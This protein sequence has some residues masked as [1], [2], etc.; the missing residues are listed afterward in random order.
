MAKTKITAL[1]ELTDTNIAIGDL[2]P[3]VDISDTSQAA[4]G[5][6]K[7]VTITSLAT[8]VA[9][10]FSGDSPTFVN[11]TTTGTTTL[12]DASGDAVTINAATI[13]LA[14]DTNFVLS[15]GV[16]GVS[17]DTDVLS[18]D[19]TNDRVGIGQTSPQSKIDA[20]FTNFDATTYPGYKFY[21]YQ[22]SNTATVPLFH[23]QTGWE[24]TRTAN[25][26]KVNT[27]Q[28]DAGFNIL[29]NGNVGIG[30]TSPGSPLTVYGASSS[31]AVFT[32]GAGSGSFTDKVFRVLTDTSPAA[33]GVTVLRNG[34]VGIGTSSFGT[35]AVAVLGLANATAPTSSPAG[36]GQLYV[37][38]GALKYRGSSGTITT[39]GAA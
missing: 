14:N 30:E 15:G 21:G 9:S 23:I 33:E 2:I 6:T 37:E 4:S 16:N 28:N 17:F 29:A 19:A 11:L 35:S 20:T 25:I 32:V 10:A 39:L 5:T 34:N 13:T 18:I 12:G 3:I 8:A 7:K 36:M 31:N 24:V 1:T 26:F 27:Y 22:S 38:A